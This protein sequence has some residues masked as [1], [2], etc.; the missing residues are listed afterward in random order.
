MWTNIMNSNEEKVP[1]WIQCTECRK[2]RIIMIKT[3]HIANWVPPSYWNCDMNKCSLP[4]E[5]PDQYSV[6]Q[7]QALTAQ[8]HKIMNKPYDWD[9]ILKANES[10]IRQWVVCCDCEQWRTVL[11][12]KEDISH[13]EKP[14]DWN[15]NNLQ[16]YTNSLIDMCSFPQIMETAISIKYSDTQVSA[17]NIQ[18]RLA[19]R[20]SKKRK[21]NTNINTNSVTKKRRLN[22]PRDNMKHSKQ[23]DTNNHDLQKENDALK[24]EVDSIKKK[25]SLYHG[26]S[27]EINTLSL[28]ELDSLDSTLQYAMNTVKEA[29]ERLLENK[30]MCIVCLKNEKNIVIQ[31]CGHFDLCNECEQQ[32]PK[33]ICPRCQQTYG[34]ITIIKH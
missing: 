22:D 4:R 19:L 3:S 2:W 28:M 31:Q 13:W 26:K 30:L 25:L 10:Q 32:L 16:N 6:V 15:C 12:P 33:K 29:R 8:R 5:N 7:R 24:E 27:A 20:G 9:P 23:T 1:Q 21:L 18:R 14:S 34:D 17:L 11:V